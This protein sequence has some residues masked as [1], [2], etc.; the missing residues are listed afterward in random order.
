[1]LRV[2]GLDAYPC[3]VLGDG[4]VPFFEFCG[5]LGGDLLHGEVD[6]VAEE[7][8]DGEDEEEEDEGEEFAGGVSW[9]HGVQIEVLVEVVMRVGKR[10]A[11]RHFR[12]TKRKET[13]F[14]R[15]GV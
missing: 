9:W 6:V 3:A 10:K 12:A 13:V 1:M 8:E 11:M 2:L 7:G 14:R 5:G 15:N 4:E